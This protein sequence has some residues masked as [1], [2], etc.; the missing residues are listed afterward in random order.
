MGRQLQQQQPHQQQ[1]NYRGRS[2]SSNSNRSSSISGGG[3]RNC[4]A[5]AA[6]VAAVAAATSAA[7]AVI[8]KQQQQQRRRQPQFSSSSGGGSRNFEAAADIVTLRI[9]MCSTDPCRSVWPCGRGTWL[10]T[11]VCP[12]CDSVHLGA[13]V[14]NNSNNSTGEALEVNVCHTHSIISINMAGQSGHA[15]CGQRAH[16]AFCNA[17]VAT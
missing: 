12:P 14:P 4:E 5:A 17:V 15:T 1:R 3:S 10:V 8:L 7:A 13:A 11:S 2:S 16:L 6:T 9:D